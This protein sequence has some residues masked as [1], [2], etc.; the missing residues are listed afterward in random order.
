MN[1]IMCAA[2]LFAAVLQAN[3]QSGTNSPYSQYGLG[4][5]TEQSAGFSRGMNGLGIGFH[6]HNQVNQLNPASYA[7]IDSL[8]FVFD[9][10]VSGQITSFEENGVKKNANNADFEYAVAG[11]RLFRHLGMSFG[12]L[13]FTNIGY[14]YSFS[15][16]VDETTRSTTYTNT[17]NGSGGIHQFYLG[18]G[19]E[20]L[21][22]FRIGFNASYLWGDYT[23]SVVNVYSDNYANR[24]SRYYSADVRSYKL[25]F[26][27]QYTA[28]INKTDEITLG[29]TYS[30]GHKIG[31]DPQLLEISTNTQT[32]VS[33]TT[34]HRAGDL[35]IPSAYGVG[36]MWNHEN[37]WKV[38]L[39]YTLQKWGDVKFPQYVQGQYI[40]MKGLLKDRHKLTAGL[41]YCP[42]PDGMS[43][44]FFE[45]IHYRAGVSYATPYIK[46]NGTDGPK[47]ISASIGFGIPI[48]NKYNNRSVLNVSGQWARASADGLIKENIFRIN[49]GLM[50]NELWFSKWKF[51]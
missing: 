27:A 1:R 33:D 50:F 2:I 39:D 7:S 9:A 41:D 49:I 8:T 22:G 5:L 44:K 19:W 31:G 16:Y 28:K 4:I 14:N 42:S 10:G 23:R 47:E 11:F 40:D 20:P 17:Y 35:E 6:D 30:L 15:R 18:M 43:L 48:I 38:G 12:I 36:V 32:S 3:A 37:K 24:L 21:S 26:G 25:D 13:P 45:R 34:I 46:V 29:L 51:Q